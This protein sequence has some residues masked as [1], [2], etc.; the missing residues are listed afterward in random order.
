[1]FKFW[2]NNIYFHDLRRKF[3]EI[4][5]WVF[6]FINKTIAVVESLNYYNNNVR[7]FIHFW[8]SDIYL[9]NLHKLL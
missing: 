8:T 6:F 1:M 5:I 3:L 4:L 7:L 2:L 9:P